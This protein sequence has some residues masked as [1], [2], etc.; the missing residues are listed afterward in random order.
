MKG[1]LVRYVAGVI[2]IAEGVAI[3]LVPRFTITRFCRRHP[4]GQ[5]LF[6]ALLDLHWDGR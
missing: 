4:W 3:I 1:S 5:Y 6:N 2:F